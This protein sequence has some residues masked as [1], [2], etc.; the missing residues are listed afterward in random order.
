MI[1]LW[2]ALVTVCVTGISYALVSARA[3]QAALQE[4]SDFVVQRS[5]AESRLFVTARANLEIF[6][7]RFLELYNDPDVLPAPDFGQ[8]FFEDEH[9]ALRLRPEYFT[10][11]R[12]RNGT[13]R[14]GTSGFM[15]V[16]RPD[17]TPEL[18]RRMVLAYELVDRFGPAWLGQFDNLHASLPENALIIHWPGGN[19]GASADPRLDM[20]AGAV[21]R[22]TLQSENPE[23]RP[24]WSGLYYDL[25]AGHWAVTY[26]LPVDQD[27][28][29]LL[30]PSHDIRLDELVERLASDHP[31]G[32]RNLIMSDRG[33]LVAQPERMADIM[34]DRGVLDIEK[35]EDPALR[36]VY[37]TLVDPVTGAVP[38]GAGA[39][40][41]VE[42]LDAYVAFARIE[43]PDW[44]F[45]TIYP[46]SLVSAKAHE[47]AAIVLL[48]G[49]LLL[50]MVLMVILSVLRL[51]VARPLR[52]MEL[53]SRRIAQGDHQSISEGTVPLP[54]EREDE[55]G[56]LSRAFRSMASEIG[57]ASA[58]LE[59]EVAAR[60]VELRLANHRLEQLS[61]RDGL[62]GAFNRRAFDRDLGSA[63][64]RFGECGVPSA[65]LLCD[66][67]H[68]KAYN[69]SYGHVAGDQV[70]ALIASTI[71][72]SAP[73]GRVYRYGG[74][75]FSIILDPMLCDPASLGSQ[76]VRR[77]A[78]LRIP[79]RASPFGK[80]TLSV[81]VADCQPGS[82]CAAA[83]V[84]SAD[85]QLYRAKTQGRNR[86]LVE[87][88]EDGDTAAVA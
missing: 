36:A 8:W 17:L 69:D 12:D 38:H 41:P 13:L 77:I 4:L 60:T 80:V 49:L 48:L 3:E 40:I 32:A 19:W 34:K 9:G 7:E 70:L 75:E 64:R 82:T 33:Q 84:R 83:L 14:Q 65:L 58:V 87:S 16:S 74:E 1:V 85:A 23:R 59:R 21:I 2:A 76:L 30:N 26:Q 63:M 61:L 29:H 31:P 51:Q 73:D 11:R 56:A 57:A 50:A 81:G 53:A 67:D 72:Q 62:T 55:I 44:W 15:G 86:A 88:R 39:V 6:R 52:A 78:S 24:V 47:G 18:Q 35:L 79:H 22:A 37:R 45:V 46:R 54:V 28:R 42:E 5:S 20:T 27:G 25:T 71:A 43:G 68:F 10:G 66:I